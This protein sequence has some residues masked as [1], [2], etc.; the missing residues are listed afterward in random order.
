V[1]SSC[2]HG[3]ELSVS[4]KCKHSCF[5]TWEIISLSREN[6]V[7]GVNRSVSRTVRSGIIINERWIGKD[8]EGSGQGTIDVISTYM[9][10]ASEEQYKILNQDSRC[11]GSE[12]TQAHR[13]EVQ[14]AQWNSKIWC[15]SQ[16]SR[17]VLRSSGLW[18]HIMF[19]G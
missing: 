15:F 9:S 10:G 19:G 7:H 4:I 13:T 3:N 12:S 14:L 5:T 1:T 18:G 17:F 16:K 8:V 2:K 6:V 11:P